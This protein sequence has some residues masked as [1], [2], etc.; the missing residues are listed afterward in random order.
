MN[1]YPP[2]RLAD[3]YQ[4]KK[5]QLSTCIFFTESIECPG[6]KP[7]LVTIPIV[8]FCVGVDVGAVL[9]RGR[10]EP[11]TVVRLTK[12]PVPESWLLERWLVDPLT[13]PP[14]V[15]Q[16]Q[17]ELFLLPEKPSSSDFVDNGSVFFG[18][19]NL[20]QLCPQPLAITLCPPPIHWSVNEP[21]KKWNTYVSKK[22]PKKM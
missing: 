1:R 3:K 13:L 14:S 4:Y 2:E 22:F 21:N 10:K 11:T 18:W 8:P 9:P 12:S 5:L 19:V 6:P 15:C 20:H 7:V 17:P 16:T